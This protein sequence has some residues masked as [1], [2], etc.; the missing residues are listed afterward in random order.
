LVDVDRGYTIHRVSARNSLP[1]WPI[2]FAIRALLATG[3]LLALFVLGAAAPA[4]ADEPGDDENVSRLLE[5]RPPPPVI[6]PEGSRRPIVPPKLP[7]D[8]SMV[9]G[10]RCRIEP[11]GDTAWK[12]I[13]FEDEPNVP[14]LKPRIA[15][16]C[17][18]LEEMERQL[19]ASPGVAFR[20][21]GENAVYQNRV[22]FLLR[23]VNVERP[24]PSAPPHEPEPSASSQ[25]TTDEA[26]LSSRSIAARLLEQ[27]KDRPVF[28]DANAV[29][30]DLNAPSVAPVPTETSIPVVSGDLVVDR[31]VRILYE[32]APGGWLTA[33]FEGDNNL[34]EPPVRLLPC[35]LLEVPEQMAHLPRRY[36]GVKYRISG[37]L[38]RYKGRRYLLLRKRIR[39]HEMGQ[40]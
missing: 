7:P 11:L 36:K 26:G 40:L 8:G 4:D 5:D 25:P 22:F 37:E 28:S 14:S 9:I 34:Q 6:R 29:E 23:K 35:R 24:V 3:A 17:E 33:R 30:A 10:R 15:L 1:V 20:V 18:L 13:R 19:A 32:D 39:E 12:V 21:S 38:L 27:A 16:P 31:V 2:G